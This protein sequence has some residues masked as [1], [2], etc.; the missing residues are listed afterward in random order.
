MLGP[1]IVVRATFTLKNGEHKFL[2]T[3]MPKS[4]LPEWVSSY[5]NNQNITKFAW[6]IIPVNHSK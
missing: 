6:E 5:E 3:R 2:I 1:I 4:E